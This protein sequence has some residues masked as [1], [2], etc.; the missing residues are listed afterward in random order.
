MMVVAVIAALVACGTS[1][2]PAGAVCTDSSE[3]EATDSC[4]E[5]GQFSGSAC[6]VVGKVCSKNC[7]TNSDCAEL[8][9]SFMCFASCGSAMV[10]GAT[11]A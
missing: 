4:L 10:C 6:T 9:P 11:A 1:S 7:T 2:K 3:C 8:G 5:L